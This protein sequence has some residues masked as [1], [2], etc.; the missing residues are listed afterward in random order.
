MARNAFA[1][2]FT[3]VSVMSAA[4]LPQ[5]PGDAGMTP[6][7]HHVASGANPCAGHAGKAAIDA[8]CLFSCTASATPAL[9]HAAAWRPA[10]RVT[11]F[12][13]APAAQAA[14]LRPAPPQRPPNHDFRAA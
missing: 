12:P 4:H 13:P 9:G 6:S 7:M 10:S 5:M 8:L 2:V 1:L 3:V 11:D 14:G